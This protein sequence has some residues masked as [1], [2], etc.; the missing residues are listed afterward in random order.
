MQ[1]KLNIPYTLWRQLLMEVCVVIVKVFIYS[2]VL[3]FGV[4]F[5]VALQ[6][7]ILLSVAHNSPFGISGRTVRNGGQ[8]RKSDHK[9]QT[10]WGVPYSK[11]DK[12]REKD[13]FKVVSSQTQFGIIS[14]AH[15]KIMREY[16]FLVIK[17][18]H[19]SLCRKLIAVRRE[20][21]KVVR[22]AIRSNLVWVATLN[23]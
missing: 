20:R 17:F 3:W 15:T 21:M 4:Y 18:A 16:E 19:R 7:S 6:N 12:R 11:V 5:F 14:K 9:G 13:E 8:R 10:T 22:M 1:Q 23:L 2:H